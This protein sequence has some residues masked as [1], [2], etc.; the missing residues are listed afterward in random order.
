M[1][2]NCTDDDFSEN[3]VLQY[4]SA[5]PLQEIN[6]ESLVPSMRLAA[7]GGRGRNYVACSSVHPRQRRYATKVLD[8]CNYC[9]A[10]SRMCRD[11]QDSLYGASSTTTATQNITLLHSLELF[12]TQAEPELHS[13][14]NSD[15]TS[16]CLFGRGN[17]YTAS[18]Q[19][20]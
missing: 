15:S 13:S 10:S 2:W 5:L 16:I 4:R 17:R 9:T 3:T 11:H 14:M 7:R 6:T 18:R 1:P 20:R 19:H 8:E 12:V